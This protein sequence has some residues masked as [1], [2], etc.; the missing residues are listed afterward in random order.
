MNR[1]IFIV[2]FA[3]T[4]LIILT[5][6]SSAD[7]MK[8]DHEKVCFTAKVLIADGE[9]VSFEIIDAGTSDFEK[10]DVFHV[11]VKDISSPLPKLVLWDYVSI[12]CR[13]DIRMA[14]KDKNRFREIISI[15][16]TDYAGNMICE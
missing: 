15:N 9:K 14:G 13:A 16:K 1:K 10:G 12:E 4:S 5:F 3:F 6:L 2:I 8:N 11:F 7:T